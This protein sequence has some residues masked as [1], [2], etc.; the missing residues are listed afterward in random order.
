[1]V[2]L[3]DDLILEYIRG[4]GFLDGQVSGA[5][6]VVPVRASF[7]GIFE[8]LTLG[9]AMRSGFLRVEELDEFGSVP[10]VLVVNRASLPVLIIDGEELEGAKQD[11]IVNASILLR[12]R[13]KTVI[14]VSCV[15]AGRWHHTSE[16]FK[17][18]GRVAAKSVRFEKTMSV[19]RSLES[20]LGYLSDQGA[21]WDSVDKLHSIS[22]SYSDTGA[23]AE[24]FREHEEELDKFVKPFKVLEGQNGILVA[25]NGK[26]AGL[27]F[28]SNHS[29]Y[30]KLHD[31]IIKSYAIEALFQNETNKL[32]NNAIEAFIDEIIGANETRKK[33]PGYG[34]DYRFR[35]N[36]C[37]G[38]ALIHQGEII[39][40]VF[41]RLEEDE[42]MARR[43]DRIIF[44][45][46]SEF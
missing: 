24:A 43:R 1:M 28:V 21:V 26:I 46:E 15:E 19:T 16:S 32:T 5:M 45:L 29:T 33:S 34:C 7:D 25:I 30:K 42:R 12:E 17:D 22:G 13:S 20:R 4:L 14:P 23:M 37:I 38:S 39:H 40:G 3:L 9:E 27:E 11:R 8:Y 6:E 10:E 31:K 35:S 41:F 18:P 44:R 2:V 36:N